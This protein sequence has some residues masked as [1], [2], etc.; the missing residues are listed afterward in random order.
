MQ[1]IQYLRL[2]SEKKGSLILA[3]IF[4][5]ALS[6][7]AVTLVSPR[8]KVTTDFMVAQVNTT[9]QDF[10]TLFKSSEY[11][12]KILAE[13]MQSERFINAVIESGKVSKE[14]LP[15]DKRER[16]EAWREMVTVRSMADL[17]MLSVVVKADTDREASKVMQG[18]TEVL[19][20]RNAEFRGGDEKAIEMRIL[21]GPIT[22]RNPN[23]K[24]LVLIVVTGF[25]AGVSL[26]TLRIVTRAALRGY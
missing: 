2:V 1:S 18:I 21:S 6:F 23:P 11:L 16:L 22:E 25:L 15:T 10:Y 3:G 24:E 7:F 13:S 8:F 4:V 26:M 20:T 5:A 12:G 9:S 17:G 19:M 14:F